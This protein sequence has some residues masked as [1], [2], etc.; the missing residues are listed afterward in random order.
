[1]LSAS[2]WTSQR[3]QI[4]CIRPI[5]GIFTLGNPSSSI[6]IPTIES[7]SLV[8]VSLQAL[9]SGLSGESASP[10]SISIVPGVGFTVTGNSDQQGCVYTYTVFIV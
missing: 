5:V 9:G 6:N 8:V 4:V 3:R 7:T 2:E 10:L 1:M